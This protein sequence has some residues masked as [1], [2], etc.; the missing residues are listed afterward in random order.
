MVRF[1]G[2]GRYGRV[3]R[4]VQ[5]RCC[6]GAGFGLRQGEIFGLSPDD[7]DREAESVNVVRQVRLVENQPVF[8]PPK[9]RKTR[10]APLASGILR[11]LDEYMERFPPVAL[12]LPWLHPDGDPVTTGCTHC[13][14]CSPRS[15]STRGSR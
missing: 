10:S 3:A 9:R 5:D 12:T 14:T 13:G 1:E 2:V 4:P 15:C 8:A 11:E 6:G 7:L